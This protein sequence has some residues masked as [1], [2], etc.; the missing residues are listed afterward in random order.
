VADIPGANVM[1]I[2]TYPDK[3]TKRISFPLNI[4]ADK[5]GTYTIDIT[6]SKQGYKTIKQKELFGV[7]SQNANIQ[8]ALITGSVISNNVFNEISILFF[9]VFLVLICL[10]LFI[11]RYFL[12]KK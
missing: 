2:L 1:A 5:I 4:K 9:I 11:A 3:T 10:I 12:R 6:A 8:Q 7:I